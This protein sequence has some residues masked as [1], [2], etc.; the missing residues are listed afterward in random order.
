MSDKVMCDAV[1][2]QPNEPVDKGEIERQLEWQKDELD[3]LQESIKLLGDKLSPVLSEISSSN[4]KG[5]LT[6]AKT[7]YGELLQSNNNQIENL[8]DII[9]NYIERSEL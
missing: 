3:E 8:K 5:E 2:K 7:H 9:R 4:E 1:K 6:Q